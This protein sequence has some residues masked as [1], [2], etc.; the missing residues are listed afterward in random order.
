M[1]DAVH[2][3]LL[4]LSSVALIIALAASSLEL[5]LDVNVRDVLLAPLPPPTVSAFLLS[6]SQPSRELH[7]KLL[8][9]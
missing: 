8:S 1:R 4:E 7:E 2:L 3:K 6:Y 5:K 9:P